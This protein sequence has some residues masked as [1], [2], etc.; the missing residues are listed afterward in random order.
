MEL[1]VIIDDGPQNWQII[2]QHKGIG[3]IRLSG[4]KILPE[5]MSG[6][7][8]AFARI[9]REESGETVIGWTE[10]EALPDAKWRLEFNNVPAGG[11]CGTCK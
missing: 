6:E 11:L 4:R 3:E 9:V 10:S 5:E 7:G 2:Q 8:R 1:G